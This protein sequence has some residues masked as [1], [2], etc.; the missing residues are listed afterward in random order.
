MRKEEGK[1]RQMALEL[2]DLREE[3]K[4]IAEVIG[5]ENYL[6]LT[7]EFGGTNIYIAK[8][9]EIIKRNERDAKIREEFN[10]N[11]C[12]Q[13]AAK[14]GLTEVWIRNIVSKKAAEIRRKPIDGQINLLEFIQ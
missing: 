7:K 5:V 12:T 1:V 13:L 10:G 4:R 9:E 14:Y 2:D 8:A 11:N 3:Q 6:K